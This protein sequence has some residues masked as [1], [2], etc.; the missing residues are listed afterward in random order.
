MFLPIAEAR[1][2]HNH[3]LSM[4]PIKRIHST[5]FDKEYRTYYKLHRKHRR[6][7]I[8]MA[9]DTADF[10]YAY[11]H[12]LVVMKIRQMF[13]YYVAGNNV[14]QSR[15]SHENA[16]E[17]LAHALQ[18]AEDIE[19]VWENWPDDSVKTYWEREVELYK[20]FYAYIGENIIYWWD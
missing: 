1:G 4:N 12:D 17:T 15:E 8:R 13:E 6:E 2:I 16:I 11:L 5:L 3:N 19:T 14:W 10:D 18:I 7:L 9:K 20:E